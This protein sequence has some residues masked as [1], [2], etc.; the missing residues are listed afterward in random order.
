MTARTT[1]RFAHTG[2]IPLALLFAASCGGNPPPAGPAPLAPFP[3]PVRLYSDNAGGVADS[4]RIVVRTAAEFSE[5]W[6]RATSR[7]TSP[8]A[9]PAVDF[10]RD[11]VLVVGAGRM[12]TGDEIRVDSVGLSRAMN[13][14]GQMEEGLTIIV[15]TT[16]GCRRMNLDAYPLEIVR[17]RGY[18][19]PIR[20]VERREQATNCRLGDAEFVP[21]RLGASHVSIKGSG[22]K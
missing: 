5:V 13:P 20:W 1:G 22:V 7:Q 4:V 12:I 10:A 15:R 17:V 6:T 3:A 8:P 21:P 11:M 2:A 16:V 18:A 19:G 14:Q 9:P